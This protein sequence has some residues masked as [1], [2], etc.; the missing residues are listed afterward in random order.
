MPVR[1]EEYDHFIFIV[2]DKATNADYTEL[3][4][5]LMHF[6]STYNEDKDFIIDLTRCRMIN[7]LEIGLFARVLSRAKEANRCLRLITNED[8]RRSFDELPMF[9]GRN[10]VFYDSA[11]SFTDELKQYQGQPLP[12][13]AT[14]SENNSNNTHDT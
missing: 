14:S 10:L 3:K 6:L 8:V 13:P 9:V 1:I 12:S 5:K 2:Y 11:Q 4:D 7:S